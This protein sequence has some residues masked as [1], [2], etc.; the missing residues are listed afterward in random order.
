MKIKQLAFICL[1]L[2]TIYPA[3]LLANDINPARIGFINDYVEHLPPYRWSA[4]CIKGGESTGTIT[5]LV[6]KVFKEMGVAYQWAP[7]LEIDTHQ[8]NSLLSIKYQQLQNQEVDFLVMP[9]VVMKSFEKNTL[10]GVPLYSHHASVITY[11]DTDAYDG[12]LATLK[13]YKGGIYVVPGRLSSISEHFRTQ[14]VHLEPYPE[15]D[16]ALSALT[17]GE[18]DFLVSDRFA[19]T[20]WAHQKKMKQQ[21]QFFDIDQPLRK[22]YLV[23]KKEGP[24]SSLIETINTL[25]TKYNNNGYS[26]FLH[27]Y[28]LIEWVKN[29]CP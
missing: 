27:R 7:S 4:S 17:S 12:N 2:L 11:G 23:T 20:I 25:V 6:D 28:Y 16:L 15:I 21:L 22:V 24:Y 9:E 26:E 3:S 5:H 13:S 1:Y 19:S 8:Q 14:Q 18:I 10:T 29:P